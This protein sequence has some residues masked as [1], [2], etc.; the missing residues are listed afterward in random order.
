MPD[1]K[2]SGRTLTIYFS[3]AKELSEIQAA[4]LSAK[5]PYAQ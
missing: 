3:T 5:I 4:A 2:Y 1:E